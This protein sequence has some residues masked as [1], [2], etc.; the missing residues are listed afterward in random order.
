[1]T[2]TRWITKP[3]QGAD[4]TF[5]RNLCLCGV[6]INA[7]IAQ[8]QAHGIEAQLVA[9]IPADVFQRIGCAG[10]DGDTPKGIVH[11]QTNHV[12]GWIGNIL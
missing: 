3:P 2:K 8:G 4:T 5:I 1:V 6:K 7:V 11:T 12:F 10:M 9:D